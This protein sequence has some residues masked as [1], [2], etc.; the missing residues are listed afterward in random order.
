[1]GAHGGLAAIAL[2]TLQSTAAGQ[3]VPP[4]EVAPSKESIRKLAEEVANPLANVATLSFEFNWDSGVGPNHD[5]RTIL[6]LQPQVPVP[7][8]K[9]WTLL[10]RFQL[11]YISQPTLVQGSDPSFGFGDVL[12]SF[13]LTPTEAPHLVWAVGPLFLLPMTTDPRLGGGTWDAGLTGGAALVQGNWQV[14]ALVYQLWPFADTGDISRPRVNHSFVHPFITYTTP[15]ALT[16]TLQ[17]ETTIDWTTQGDTK[18]TI[19]IEF[20]ISRLRLGLLPVSVQLGG[21][22]FVDTPTGGP[23]WRLRLAFVVVVPQRER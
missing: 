15:N 18:T 12:F 7:L 22:V 1:M 9:D 11:P 2:L 23:E 10:T 3:P 13:F 4:P 16:F 5:L 14:G 20:L 8:S 17:G 6:Y 21:G 19:P